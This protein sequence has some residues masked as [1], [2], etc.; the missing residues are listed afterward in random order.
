MRTRNMPILF[1]LCCCWYQQ[2]LPDFMSIFEMFGKVAIFSEP[3]MPK[4]VLMTLAACHCLT[5]HTSKLLPTT[6]CTVGQN[7]QL[8]GNMKNVWKLCFLYNI[9]VFP[10]CK[11][12]KQN[13]AKFPKSLYTLFFKNKLKMNVVK[14]K[15]TKK[16][17]FIK[18]L[19]ERA[20]RFSNWLS[21]TLPSLTPLLCLCYLTITN[22]TISRA[23]SQNN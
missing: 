15:S 5:P 3:A 9:I 6:G 2:Y 7:Y 1:I 22:H 4:N 23:T 21:L 16:V 18:P 8:C 14:S 13:N 20:Q 11:D 12:D 17:M 10:Y 19:L